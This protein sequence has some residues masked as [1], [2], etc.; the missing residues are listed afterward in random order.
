[1]ETGFLI[2]DWLNYNTHLSG[3]RRWSNLPFDSNLRAVFFTCRITVTIR[4]QVVESS[5]RSAQ[6]ANL[7][8]KH[9]RDM[10]QTPAWFLHGCSWHY[11]S[12]MCSTVYYIQNHAIVKW[13]STFCVF[14]S[15]CLL[16]WGVCVKLIKHKKGVYT[17]VTDSKLSWM[18]FYLLYTS[19]H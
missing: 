17:L 12:I 3:K 10:K 18:G 13:K 4:T 2:Y 5:Q 11:P 14:F 6:K 7:C 9:L 15:F 16:A 19:K 8:L 1:M